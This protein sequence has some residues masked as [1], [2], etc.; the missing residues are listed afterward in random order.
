M[1][2]KTQS[3]HARAVDRGLKAKIKAKKG[4]PLNRSDKDRRKRIQ[5]GLTRKQAEKEM[6]DAI[7]RKLKG[8]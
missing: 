8:K 6:K 3:K 5:M 2:A 7:R 1:G 4:S